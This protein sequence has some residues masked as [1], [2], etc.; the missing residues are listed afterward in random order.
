MG[1]MTQIEFH[2]NTTE[3]LQYTCRLL[4][5]AH[6]RQLRVGVVGSE[7]SLRQL[8]AALWSFSECDFLPHS[9]A[10]DGLEVQVASPIRLHMDPVQLSGMDV[11]V[12]L[13]DEVPQG[14]ESFG[15]LIEIV[16]TDDHGRMT[17]RQRWRHYTAQGYALKQH[18]LSKAVAT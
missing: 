6:A 9:S 3:R 18:D 14:F 13:G 15:R 2:F 10:A 12:N 17:A 16:A 4:R 8:D 1:F 11:L 5:K 7:A